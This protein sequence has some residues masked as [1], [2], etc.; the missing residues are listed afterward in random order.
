MSHISTK[1]SNSTNSNIQDCQDLVNGLE[2]G[3]FSM[4][5]EDTR[6][7]GFIESQKSVNLEAKLLKEDQ[8]MPSFD[9]NFKNHVS[10]YEKIGEITIIKS[11]IVPEEMSSQLQ[12]C[13]LITNSIEVG[14]L[15]SSTNKSQPHTCTGLSGETTQ[16]TRIKSESQKSNCSQM[17]KMLEINIAKNY[18]FTHDPETIME[19]NLRF[20]QN[21]LKKTLTPKSKQL[22]EF[23]GLERKLSQE[24]NSG[25]KDNSNS[26]IENMNVNYYFS[27]KKK[28]KIDTNIIGSKEKE[29]LFQNVKKNEIE[30]KNLEKFE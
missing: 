17:E 14:I 15:E 12:I 24:S 28:K 4:N 23:K 19:Q 22:N 10:P 1:K 18:S 16:I 21:Q 13:E 26:N 9:L 6:K 5:I 25:K 29:K 30:K 27:D 2:N 7:F 3:S 20:S 8:S 11:K